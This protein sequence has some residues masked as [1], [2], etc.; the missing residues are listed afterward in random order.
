MLAVNVSK[1]GNTEMFN[2]S[3]PEFFVLPIG[4]QA[5]RWCSVVHCCLT[6]VLPHSLKDPGSNLGSAGCLSV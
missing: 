4:I 3:W 2:Y 5:A 6:T 1:K